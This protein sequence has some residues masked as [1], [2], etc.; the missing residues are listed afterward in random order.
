MRQDGHAGARA[1]GDGLSRLIVRP[2][3]GS[4]LGEM[5]AQPDGFLDIGVSFVEPDEYR[6]APAST[7]SQASGVP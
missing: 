4:R 1:G 3:D 5:F 6:L 7:R 2:E